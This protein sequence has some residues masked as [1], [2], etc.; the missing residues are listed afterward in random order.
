VAR[1]LVI[2]DDR[3]LLRALRVGLLAKGHHMVA[4]ATA[5]E[6][7][8]QLAI[9]QPDV[10]VLDLGL[11]D[12]D[13]LGLCREIRTMSKIPLVVL[14]ANGM[15]LTKVQALDWG[16]DDYVTKPFGMAELE[17]RIR[18]A[19]AHSAQASSVNGEIVAGPLRLDPSRRQASLGGTLLELTAREFDLLA[20]FA[21]NAGRICTHQMILQAVWGP[22]WQES[23]PLRAYVYRLRR[24]LSD[25]EGQ[26]LRSAP[27]IGYY[28][29]C[30]PGEVVE[31]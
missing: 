21:R 3:S 28:L 24:K 12:R 15:E 10:V 6:G 16:A 19:L 23:E 8:V 25:R 13:G 5:E 22:G 2:D 9:A 20:Y 29:A 7:L 30:D 11:P 26:L 27:G 4:A 17:A 1:V 31:S 14:S 18:K